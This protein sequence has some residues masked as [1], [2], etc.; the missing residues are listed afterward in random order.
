MERQGDSVAAEDSD[1]MGR[2]DASPTGAWSTVD[3]D[4]PVEDI[5]V[6]ILVKTVSGQGLD[7]EAELV[8][9]DLPPQAE[10]PVSVGQ[11]RSKLEE[12]AQEAAAAA[13]KIQSM[14]RGN[15]ARKELGQQQ[16]AAV[17]IQA[18]QRG[19]QARVA[20]RVIEEV[21]TVQA[22]TASK[23]MQFWISDVVDSIVDDVV[24]EMTE[25]PVAFEPPPAVAEM[26]G[27]IVTAAVERAA[28]EAPELTPP[29]SPQTSASESSSRPPS[30]AASADLEPEPEPDAL[31]AERLEALRQRAEEPPVTPMLDGDVDDLLPPL[32]LEDIDLDASDERRENADMI[33]TMLLEMADGVERIMVKTQAFL[34]GTTD[35]WGTE[36]HKTSDRRGDE[37]FI[38]GARHDTQWHGVG[39]HVYDDSVGMAPMVTVRQVREHRI[40]SIG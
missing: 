1:V 6:E 4:E 21:S 5:G 7:A 8:Q 2:T 32:T 30:A 34:T 10:P 14:Q 15:Q 40:N 3:P 26:V 23:F 29:G 24:D 18:V 35:G 28:V 9:V 11:R 39:E 16:A 17:K 13:A 36:W 12:E 22:H 33:R 37:E 38:T 27:E 25:I 19:K 31:S 20:P